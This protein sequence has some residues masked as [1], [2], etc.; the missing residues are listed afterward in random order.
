MLTE[1]TLLDL[2]PRQRPDLWMLQGSVLASVDHVLEQLD[3]ERETPLHL[4]RPDA[5]GAD[6]RR[7]AR[8]RAGGCSAGCGGPVGAAPVRER[9]GGVAYLLTAALCAARGPIV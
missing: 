3:L 5:T 9:S 7:A 4:L 6:P 2:D 8:G 1:L